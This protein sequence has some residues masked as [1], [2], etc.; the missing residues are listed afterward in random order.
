MEYN[1]K[2]VLEDVLARLS[3]A[4]IGLH[5]LA[6]NTPDT[7]M[8]KKAI[9]ETHF[10]AVKNAIGECMVSLSIIKVREGKE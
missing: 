4:A 10:G 7:E 9:F 1:E 3:G 6:R 2:E 5:T 8:V